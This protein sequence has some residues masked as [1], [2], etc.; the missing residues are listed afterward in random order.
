MNE[1]S[2]QQHLSLSL[3]LFPP[4]LPLSVAKTGGGTVRQEL[5]QIGNV[6]NSISVFRL[7]IGDIRLRPVGWWILVPP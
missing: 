4:G 5:D 1:Q 7:Q 3:S 2:K 6:L